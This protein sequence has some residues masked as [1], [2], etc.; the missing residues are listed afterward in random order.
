M[1]SLARLLRRAVGYMRD[2]RLFGPQVFLGGRRDGSARLR[3]LASRLGRIHYRPDQ[4]DLNAFRQ[5]FG[6]REYDISRFPQWG[7][8]QDR[9]KALLEGGMRPVILDAGGN[10]GAASI[11]FSRTFPQAEIVCV[12]PDPENARIARLNTG[13]IDRIHVVEAAIGALP[14]H[15]TVRQHVSGDAWAASTV[16]SEAGAPVV[17]VS[18]CVA[19]VERGALLIAKIDIEGFEA[20]LFSANTDWIDE[21][22]VIFVELHDWMRSHARSSL[23]V[24]KA[25]FTREREL[26]ICG[27]NL[28]FV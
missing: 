7:G 9:Y 24:Q 23:P 27:E 12:E 8:V 4:S 11:W 18:D 28:V 14:G 26:L 3:V 2:A 20:D 10:V 17:T 25:M 21:A 1:P 5:V 13:D 6:G 22:A 19:T 16:R 15:V